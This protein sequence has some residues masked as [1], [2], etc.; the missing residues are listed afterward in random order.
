MEFIFD[1]LQKYKLE[2]KQ[3]IDCIKTGF[4][5]FDSKL[6]GGLIPGLYLFGAISGLGKSTF[7]LQIADYIASCGH[8]VMFFSL[9]MSKFELIS[10]SLSRFLLL[11]GIREKNP[12]FK[13]YS[14]KRIMLGDIGEIEADF[15]KVL[16]N[17]YMN[18][19]CNMMIS[20]ERNLDNI[21][22]NIEFV[23]KEYKIRPIIFIDY[24]QLIRLSNYNGDVRQTIN[25]VVQNLKIISDKYN[26][27]IWCISSFNRENYSTQVNLSCFKESGDLEYTAN[28]VFGMQYD[29]IRTNGKVTQ[30]DLEQLNTS[31]K[32]EYNVYCLKDRFGQGFRTDFCFYGKN[33][34][35]EETLFD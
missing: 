22:K 19:C 27:I 8:K 32:K 5:S 2:V 12:D 7:S 1:Y 14:A 24:I 31:L 20:T 25:R 3:G 15:N 10:K 17:D 11:K 21:I 4:T 16:D 13:N 34:Y 33:N 23:I 9:E 6:N 35:Y 29:L 18:V 28:G 30:K 26:L